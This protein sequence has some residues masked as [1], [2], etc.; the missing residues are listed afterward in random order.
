MSL[1]GYLGVGVVVDGTLSA[2]HVCATD[3][4]KRGYG[5]NVFTPQNQM[6]KMFSLREG[7]TRKLPAINMCTWFRHG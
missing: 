5:E 4:P 7:K 6:V 2:L 3:E 1:D